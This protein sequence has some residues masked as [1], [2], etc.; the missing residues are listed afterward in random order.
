MLEMVHSQQGFD[1]DVAL[2]EKMSK[3]VY[4]IRLDFRLKFSVIQYLTFVHRRTDIFAEL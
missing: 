2:I 4:K 1:L 3:N